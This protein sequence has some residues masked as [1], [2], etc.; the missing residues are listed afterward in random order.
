MTLTDLASTIEAYAKDEESAQELLALYHHLLDDHMN[1]TEQLYRSEMHLRL[2]IDTAP[3]GIKITSGMSDDIYINHTMTDYLG[4]AGEELEE[5]TPCERIEATTHPDFH[6]EEMTYVRELEAGERDSYRLEKQLLREDGSVFWGDITTSVVRDVDGELISKMSILVDITERKH[7]EIALRQS[8]ERYRSVVASMTEGVVMHDASGIITASNPQAEVILGLTLEQMIGFDDHNAGCQIIDEDGREYR[9]EDRPANI[10]L[11][12]GRPCHNQVMGIRNATGKMT[13]I[14]VNAEPVFDEDDLTPF[15]VV[16]TISDI[17]E[18][19]RQQQEL[20][21]KRLEEERTRL[22]LEFIQNAAHEFRTP[23]SVINSAAYLTLRA[24]SEEKRQKFSDSIRAQVQLLSSLVNDLVAMA[25]LDSGLLLRKTPMDMAVLVAQIVAPYREQSEQIITFSHGGERMLDCD[26]RYLTMAV[27]KLM[28]NAVQFTA[29]GGEIAVESYHDGNA[30]TLTITDTGCG[31][32][33]AELERAF[34]RFWR[35]DAAHTCAGFGLGLPI[36]R[37]VIEAHDGEICIE[38]EEGIGTR[39]K[40]YLPGRS[41]L[42]D[43]T[44]L[45]EPQAMGVY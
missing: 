17:T 26:V 32:T 20:F 13:W 31:M 23:L 36:A 38:S 33:R 15:A 16:S 35:A 10:V 8:E 43:F 29:P 39:I 30:Y 9:I 44:Y 42:D 7:A 24:K 12:T 3:V 45:S 40:V 25:E 6:E 21:E 28:D 37:S 27:T 5:M 2:L 34:E 41:P 14:S 11:Q 19:R 1:M 4:F 18:Q 22:L